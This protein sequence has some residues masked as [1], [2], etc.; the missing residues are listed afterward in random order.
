MVWTVEHTADILEAVADPLGSAFWRKAKEPYR[1]LAACDA[2]RQ[3]ENARG[4]PLSEQ[5]QIHIPIAADATASMLQH[6]A[7]M[8]KDATLASQV[9][10]VAVPLEAA[11]QDFYGN[12]APAGLSREDMKR[13][14][15][16]L[17]GQTFDALAEQL[18]D[19]EA[20]QLMRNSSE[21]RTLVAQVGKRRAAAV[22]KATNRFA[23]HA[24]GYGRDKAKAIR[25]AWD[26]AAPSATTERK[27]LS[28]YARREARAGR[29]LEGR[30]PDGFKV[31]QA[32]RVKESTKAAVWLCGD[33]GPWLLEPRRQVLTEAIDVRAQADGY[34]PNFVH[35]HDAALLRQIVRVGTAQGIAR[36]GVAHDSVAVHANDGGA[37]RGCAAAAVRWLYGYEGAEVSWYTFS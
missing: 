26:V 11:P 35:S 31:R 32:N 19:K 15:W 25:A 28:A 6:Y 8:T 20:L 22:L 36:W 27:R 13:G 24:R 5:P 18:G 1:F 23:R 29:P 7:L 37:M 4:L 9:N 33:V 10:M 16:I 14:A 3:V 21:F 12:A 17:Y 2:W 30:L 34:P